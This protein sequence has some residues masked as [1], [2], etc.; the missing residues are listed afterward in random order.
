M[1]FLLVCLEPETTAWLN[2]F[3]VSIKWKSFW[4]PVEILHVLIAWQEHCVRNISVFRQNFLTRRDIR[5]QHKKESNYFTGTYKKSVGTSPEVLHICGWR[6]FPQLAVLAI[7]GRRV[8]FRYSIWHLSLD[9]LYNSLL[10]WGHPRI[11]YKLV[12]QCA[13]RR[14]RWLF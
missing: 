9:K 4:F 8:L 12:F 11:L 3:I 10:L 1:I 2:C 14:V 6:V 5:S 7:F 13:Y